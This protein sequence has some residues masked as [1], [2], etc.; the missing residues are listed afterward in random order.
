M[1][2]RLL[3]ALCHAL[4]GITTETSATRILQKIFDCLKVHLHAEQS[5]IALKNPKTDYIEAVHCKDVFRSASCEFRRCVGNNL[6]GRLF[7]AEP[8]VV[9][10]KDSPQ[11]D[12]RELF[13]EKDYA[14]AVATRISYGGRTLGFLASYFA[15]PF[16]VDTHVKNFFL[17]VG[18][19]V[20]IVLEREETFK[21]LAE[22]RRFD[23]VTGLL[24]NSFFM[25]KLGEEVNK[26][27]RF[28]WPLSVILLDL[29]NF[30]QILNLHGLERGQAVL[31]GVA[32][33]L[34]A[35]LRGVD[36][37]GV[38]GT[39]EFIAFMPN[40]PPEQAEAVMKRFRQNLAAR[41]FTDRRIVTSSSIGI[42]GLRPNE[43]LDDLVWRVQSALFA[44]RKK[45]PGM[46]V[47]LP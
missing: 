34:K 25:H 23:P 16:P 27:G 43:T 4:Q 19:A 8:L 30:K 42:T 1:K 29:D 21:A 40:T 20:S 18:G 44:A 32:D 11:E 36:V 35:C 26:S 39:D 28:G 31:V 22:L 13:L 47:T 33:E 17:A 2:D 10:T 46:I 3:T 6:I 37:V 5:I 41:D 14:L 15:E 12:Y 38:A 24:C 9:V 45:G 7:Y